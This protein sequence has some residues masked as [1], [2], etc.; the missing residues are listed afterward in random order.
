MAE[1][2]PTQLSHADDGID[3]SSS[4][5]TDHNAYEHNH[6]VDESNKR[7]PGC[8]GCGLS[9]QHDE[10]KGETLADG[11]MVIDEEEFYDATGFAFSERKK[12]TILTVIFL[13]QCSMNFNASVYGNVASI[14][15]DKFSITDEY[16]RAGQA[17]FLIAYGFGCEFC[18]CH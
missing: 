14:L 1:A 15:Q 17:S 16:S 6:P 13:V 10:V 5:S 2:K 12:W 11:R 9:G 3:A 4:S 8:A 18:E 7:Q